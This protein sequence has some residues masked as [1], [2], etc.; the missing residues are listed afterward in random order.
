MPFDPE[1][2]VI[3]SAVP[4]LVVCIPLE[5]ETPLVDEVIADTEPNLDF[6]RPRP[7][8]PFVFDPTTERSPEVNLPRFGV[9]AGTIAVTV[10]DAGFGGILLNKTDT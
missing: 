8:R 6:L 9:N 2:T 10:F 1:N 7:P 4:V 3:V 5:F